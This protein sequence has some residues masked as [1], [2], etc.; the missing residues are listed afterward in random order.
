[1]IWLIW[2]FVIEI[3]TSVWFIVASLGLVL[4]KLKNIWKSIFHWLMITRKYQQLQGW[5]QN[6]HHWGSG[7]VGKNHLQTSVSAN[8]ANLISHTITIG[9][10]IGTLHGRL[11]SITAHSDIAKSQASYVANLK[12]NLRKGE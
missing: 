4:L 12:D 2:L 5:K 6:R 8:W 7:R 3:T 11:D 1:M 9:D 10:Y